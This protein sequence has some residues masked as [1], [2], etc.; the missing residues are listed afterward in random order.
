M[1][2][3]SYVLSEHICTLTIDR[4]R[5]F[6]ALNREVLVDLESALQR[7]QADDPRCVIIT[8]AGTRAFVAGADVREMAAMSRSEAAAFSKLGNRT[9]RMLERLP[10]PTIAAVNGYALGGGC[11]LAMSC[12]IRLAS[13][14]AVFGQPEVGLGITPGFG[15]TQRLA[16]L[17]GVG[18][19]SELL[20][21]TRRIDAARAHEIGLVNGVFAPD[22]LMPAAKQLAAE[23]A[24][25][26]PIA[27]RA[28]K[29]ALSLGLATDLDLALA[30]EV[31][32]FAACFE[33]ADQHEAMTAFL[34]KRDAAPFQGK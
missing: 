25:Q 14:N 6:N 18:A 34:D 11:E 26:A 29:D 30:I 22:E 24:G 4:E 5:A 1:S 23:I 28:T 3:V 17:V 2:H 7:V 33:T 16:R 19:A 15:G 8:G 20:Y 32:R 13:N 9:F 12:D 31:T 10:M 21:S 27:V